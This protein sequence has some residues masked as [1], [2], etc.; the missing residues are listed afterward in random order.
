VGSYHGRL[1][2]LSRTL[3]V[4]I[5]GETVIG[6]WPA[7]PENH[8]LRLTITDIPQIAARRSI[9]SSIRIMLVLK[10]LSVITLA[11][12]AAAAELADT[13]VPELV[14]DKTYVPADCTVKAQKGDKLHVH[15][16][17][18]VSFF[19]RWPSLNLCLLSRLG[20][21]QMATRLTRGAHIPRVS[22]RDQP[23]NFDTYAASIATPYHSPVRH[24]VDPSEG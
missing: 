20:S 18:G 5:L 16:V 3:T 21:S 23:T 10:W 13:D 15:Y 17:G 2:C 19:V 7:I 4:L 14:I 11:A 24:N 22:P 1:V 9:K 12:L 6:T 8:S